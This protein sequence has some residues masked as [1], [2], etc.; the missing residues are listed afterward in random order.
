[1]SKPS[2]EAGRK[3]DLINAAIRRVA[4]AGSHDVTV[5][6]IAREAGM[7][8]ALAHHYFGSKEQMLLM[9]MRHILREYGAAVRAA[10]V[11]ADGPHARIEAIFAVSFGP[12]HFD[13]EVIAAWFGFYAL[14]QTNP[15]AARLLRVY[16]R[17]LRANL[18]ADLRKLTDDAPVVADAL[19][20]LIDGLYIRAA[21]GDAAPQGQ[22]AQAVLSE[23]LAR[24]IA[25]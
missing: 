18:A 17:R 3:A 22:A 21:L 10:L 12:V 1:M 11:G 7:S 4:Q 8:P 20:A 23:T 9:A 6:E 19:A 14:A 13:R 5:A 15:D 16:Q 24:M 2:R 25:R